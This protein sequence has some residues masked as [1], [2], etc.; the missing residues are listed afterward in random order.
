MG[1]VN[2]ARDSQVTLLKYSEEAYQVVDLLD[3]LLD[4]LERLC[5]RR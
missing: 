5:K 4:L 2:P 3:F 1:H